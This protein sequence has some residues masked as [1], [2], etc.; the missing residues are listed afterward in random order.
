MTD[1]QWALTEPHLPVYLGGRPRATNLRDVVNAIFSI[2]K[3]GCQ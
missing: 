3:T 2:S 1:G